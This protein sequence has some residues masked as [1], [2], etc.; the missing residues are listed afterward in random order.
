MI[1]NGITD[2]ELN[3]SIKRLKADAIYA[4]DSVS[5][6]AM[7]I[8]YNLITG[9][10]LD[11]IEYWPYKIE[12]VTKDQIHDVAKKYLDADAPYKNPPIEGI[13]MPPSQPQPLE[14]PSSISNT[15]DTDETL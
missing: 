13:M 6:P 9:S 12:A 3:D 1:E 5:G 8:G 11:D 14:A 15:G 7:I 10:T 2:E 4:L